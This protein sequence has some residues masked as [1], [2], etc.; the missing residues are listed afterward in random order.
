MPATDTEPIIYNRL[1]AARIERG[2]ER[3]ELSQMIGVTPQL[4]GYIE[5]GKYRPDLALA[6]R[7][8]EA[9]GLPLEQVFSLHPFEQEYGPRMM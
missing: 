4:L 3:T 5:L 1:A 9:L 6:L 8:S 7:I 2:I